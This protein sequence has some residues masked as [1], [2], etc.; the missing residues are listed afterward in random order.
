MRY[1]S[2][3]R[4]GTGVR[5]QVGDVRLFFDVEGAKLVPDG[6][7]MREQPTLVLLHGGPGLDHSEL[8][9]WFGQLRDV[10]QVVYLD[11]RENGRSDRD[12]VGRCCLE[13][14]GDDVR[15]FCDALEIRRPIVLG[16]SFGGFVAQAYATRHPDHPGA[17]I[18]SNTAARHRRDRVLDMFERLG[19]REA[20]EAA[21]AYL[22]DTSLETLAE[23][24]RRCLPLYTRRPEDP[25]AL[26]RTLPY[27][28]FELTVTFFRDE[29]HH[30]D[31]R[32]ALAGVRCPTLVIGGDDDPITP[33]ADSEDIAA[34]LPSPLVRLERFPGCG[35]PVYHDDEEGFF[36][37]VREFLSSL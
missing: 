3:H 27:A 6:T 28:N 7:V 9:P 12:G 36:R 21:A 14:W 4:E 35:H 25:D 20:R 31:F 32:D 37:V 22:S 19:G 13:R 33:A 18:L 26:A 29:F 10:A 24:V 30:F 23:Y 2:R 11:Q 15:A 16:V 17:L 34:A 5:V 8:K 1:S